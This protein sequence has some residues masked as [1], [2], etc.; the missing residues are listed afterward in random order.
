MSV[1]EIAADVYRL[2]VYVPEI[3]LQFNHFLVRDE[4][5]LLYHAGLRATFPAVRE[6]VAQV[7]DPAKIRWIGFSHFESDECGSLNQ[8]LEIAPQ[9]QAVCGV[10]GALVSLNDFAN[11]APRAMNDGETLTT[12]RRRF[13]YCRTA[14]VPHGWDAGV[15]FEETDRTLFCSDLFHQWGDVEPVTESDILGRARKTLV[16]GQAGPFAGYVPYTHETGRVLHGLADLKPA[17]LA[18]M[19]GSSFRGDGEAALRD[20]AVI[21]KEVLGPPEAAAKTA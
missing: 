2:S 17:T 14:H 6:A 5:P 8:W 15:M 13:R 11:R 9:A 21:F 3:D 20:L 7:M 4:E 16:D 12:G 10:L 19:H 18:T 1:T